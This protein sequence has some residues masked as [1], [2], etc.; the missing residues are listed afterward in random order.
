MKKTLV[1]IIL[2]GQLLLLTRQH[3]KAIKFGERAV[4]LSPNNAAFI[5]GLATILRYNGEPERALTLQNKAIRLNP[6]PSS[7]FYMSLGHTYLSLE[8]Y[9]E[10]IQAYKKAIHINPD[11]FS[12]YMGLA[13]AY[14]Q[15]RS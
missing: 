13:A 14:S 9:E 12:S 1:I 2:M 5:Y 10:S 7:M 8:R 11:Q 6:Y 4:S 3:D 15:P